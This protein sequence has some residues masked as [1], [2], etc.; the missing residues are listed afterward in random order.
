MVLYTHKFH[1]PYFI[2]VNGKE[3][4]LDKILIFNKDGVIAKTNCGWFGSNNN[5][6][7]L[8]IE[9]DCVRKVKVDFSIKTAFIV[10]VG[11]GW[12]GP[13]YA[14]Y[15]PD[16]VISLSTPTYK[17]V[18]NGEAI[19]ETNQSSIYPTIQ[20]I[21]YH[22]INGEVSEIR[23]EINTVGESIKNLYNSNMDNLVDYIEKLQ[24]LNEK[25][26][27]AHKKMLEIDENTFEVA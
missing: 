15:L 12:D 10:K 20:I 14:L 9:C 7:E 22:W 24:I 13:R 27:I 26:K 2:E 18:Y 4:E 25:Y 1:N 5:C 16:S 17:K 3:Y 23:K 8:T 21:T 6:K 19:E 11:E